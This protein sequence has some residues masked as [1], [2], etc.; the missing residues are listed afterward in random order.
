M[1]QDIHTSTIIYVYFIAFIYLI[2]NKYLDK[3]KIIY[4]LKNNIYDKEIIIDELRK[5]LKIQSNIIKSNEVDEFNYITENIELKD[6]ISKNSVILAEYKFIVDK[7]N[8]LSDYIILES[9]KAYQKY[10]FP[11]EHSKKQVNVYQA[12]FMSIDLII[13]FLWNIKV[14]AVPTIYAA[15]HHR[16][17]ENEK[18]IKNLK[19]HFNIKD[20]ENLQTRLCYYNNIEKK[21]EFDIKD[22]T[23]FSNMITVFK[24]GI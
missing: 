8:A 3:K 13:Q 10:Y 18:Y 19:E 17:F 20:T 1:Y 21:L 24:W 23:V 6:N 4:E 5:C 2:F 7:Y 15:Y 14:C 9:A 16:L 22:R 11:S 12:D